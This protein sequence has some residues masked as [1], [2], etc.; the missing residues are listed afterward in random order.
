[1]PSMSSHDVIRAAFIPLLDCAILP[2]AAEKG[3]AARHGIDLR[4]TRENSWANIRDRVSIG[5]FEVAHMLAPLPI[6]ATLGVGH[7][8]VPMV[9]PMALG[10]GGGMIT[11]SVELSQSMAAAGAAG[12]GDAVQAG[13]ALRDV[14][15]MRTRFG[16]P[17]LTFGMVY[18]F[19]THNYVLRYWLAAS[20]ID[21]DR[22]IRLVVI[23]PPFTVDALAAGQIDGFCVGEP[24]NS[25]AVDAGVG[26]VVT[27]KVAIWQE[28][29]DKVL[30]MREVWADANPGLVARLVQALYQAAVWCDDVAN[31]DELATILAIPRY[32]DC[33]PDVLLRGLT[34]RLLFA[35]GIEQAV[36][37]FI[38]FARQAA[39]FPWTS[40]AL[41][42]FSQMARWGQVP[43]TQEGIDAA[44]RTF[45][46]DIYRAALA[47]S[48]V[49]I[50]AMDAKIE[51]A[52]AA[53]TAVPS[54]NGAL[55]LGPNRFFDGMTFDPDR[56]RE[57]VGEFPI[58]GAGAAR[59]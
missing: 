59:A 3:F 21:P 31:R 34:G 28:G 15:M 50:P 18:P 4:L 56:L 7:L 45:R 5:H 49:P 58:G 33:R 25:L 53:R 6:A 32:L 41:W 24:W 30:G 40:H 23:P 47:G 38:V 44:R 46:P 9:T 27:T 52:L 57:Y 36:P 8:A 43:L 39:T 17:P 11:V 55:A 16:R 51:G 29:A 13:A 35:P 20:G 1:M 12:V 19:S 54:S 22:D 42:L 10:Q 26:R 48:D 2:V 37:D 14:V